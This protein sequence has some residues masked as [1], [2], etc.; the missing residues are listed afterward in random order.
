M[1]SFLCF[2]LL[3]VSFQTVSN[4]TSQTRTASI[5]FQLK[6]LLP[7][8][9]RMS[10]SLLTPNCEDTINHSSYIHN[11]TH[12]LVILFAKNAFFG[13]FGAFDAE[14]RRISCNL[15]ENE[16][17]TQQLALLATRMTFYGI[18]AQACP[19]IKILRLITLI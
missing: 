3:M 13:H 9:T 14:S 6:N 18:L 16:F 12:W 11:L 5:I 1:Y 4:F 7:K 19:E 15:D 17:V 8:S 10:S 2:S